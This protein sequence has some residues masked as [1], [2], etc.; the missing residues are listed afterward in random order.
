MKT[1]SLFLLLLL[2]LVLPLL[3]AS[4][5]VSVRV[6]PESPRVGDVV[7][8]AVIVSGEEATGVRYR[9]LLDGEPVFQSKNP[10]PHFSSA[11][12]PRSEGLFTLEVT[13]FSGKTALSSAAVD[14]PVSGHAPEEAG[15]D[16]IYSQY[17]GWWKNKIYTLDKKHTLESSGCALFALSH[18]LQRMG[19]ASDQILPEGLA[20][21]FPRMYVEGVG[22]STEALI[23]QAALYFGFQTLHDPVHDLSEIRDA[24]RR[25]DFFSFGFVK[26]H[27]VLAAALDE[28]AGMVRVLDSALGVTFSRKGNLPLYTRLSDGTY[29]EVSSPEDLPG[30]RW[31]FVNGAWSGGEYWMNLSDC[32]KKALRLI[33]RPWLTYK[34]GSETV[35]LN[36]SWIGSR[37][38][39]V[40]PAAEML[41]DRTERL[42]PTE[43]LTWQTLGSD[44]PLLAMVTSAKGLSLTDVSGKKLE[45]YRSMPWGRLLPVLTLG[46]EKVYVCYRGAFGYLAREGV[47]L[48]EIPEE[49]PPSA[50]LLSSGREVRGYPA[51]DT[52]SPAA[53]SWPAGTDVLIL[54]RSEGFCLAEG[55]GSR[56]WVREEDF[57][58]LP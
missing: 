15:P 7:E 54:D 40:S 23:R 33:R 1:R 17:D 42:V 31:F 13:A 34:D 43:D 21:L 25:G 18:A 32:A 49:D 27:V 51:P 14:F 30:A 24:F 8:V 29:A 56:G 41:A 50:R 28:D 53:C 3:S 11:F 55:L 20:A 52:K 46:D 48:L 36:A 47:E 6:S 5:E 39:L 2:F 38:S 45:G 35:A 58:A 57:S 9:L 44:R 10:D 26:G 19:I 22:T 12:R 37:R 4:A 16:V